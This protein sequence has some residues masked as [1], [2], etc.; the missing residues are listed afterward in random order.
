MNAVAL[1]MPRQK[2]YPLI[3]EKIPCLTTIGFEHWF[4]EA[5]RWW[6][7]LSFL[8]LSACPSAGGAIHL[9]SWP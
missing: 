9:K 7:I 2:G 4:T 8:V 3:G 1:S 5:F 6:A